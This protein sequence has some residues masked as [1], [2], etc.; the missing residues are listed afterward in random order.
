MYSHYITNLNRLFQMKKTLILT[1]IILTMIACS[2]KPNA[3]ASF[4]VRGNCDMCKERI[5]KTVLGIKGVEKANW[6]V[7]S[8][9]L[10]VS[11]DST[12]VSKLDIEKGIAATGHA[13][14]DVPMDS[15]AHDKLPECCKVNHGDMH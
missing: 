1:A 2:T 10:Q 15:I 12:V 6:D 13:T 4:F 8:K 3:E 9:M 14:N 11:Y 5:D 7:E